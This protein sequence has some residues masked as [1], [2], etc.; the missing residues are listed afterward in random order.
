MSPV[1]GWMVGL[2]L[3]LLCPSQT[4]LSGGVSAHEVGEAGEGLYARYVEAVVAEEG[5]TA[6]G[7]DDADEVTDAANETIEE[8]A[9][10]LLQYRSGSL[11]SVCT[12][13]EHCSTDCEKCPCEDD[14]ES[15][16][17]EQCQDCS[18][19]YICPLLCDTICSPGGL[20]DELT[21][22]LFQ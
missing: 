12:I 21:G 4:P 7:D 15:D 6:E 18:S 19:C 2:L 13:C 22:T 11:C 20:V 5:E 9:T 3:V 8:P 17:C 10:V 1:K 16:H 14:D